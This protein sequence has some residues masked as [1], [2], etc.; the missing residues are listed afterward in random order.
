V[1]VDADRF[2]S[3]LNPLFLWILRSPVHFLLSPGLMLLTITGRKSGK[4]YSIPVGYQR[5]AED[6]LVVM[7]SKAWRKQWW[8]NFREAGRVSMVL[9]GRER[10]GTAHVIPPET[11]EFL[12]RTETTIR[13]VPGMAG[14]FGIA[15]DRKA[16]LTTEQAET[17]RSQVAAVR[18]TLDPT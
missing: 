16:G 8:R 10:T 11:P 13:R 4:V 3:R 7:V 12:E 2:F 18:I 9:R 17:L 14:Q 5:E 6:L 1:T 15:Y